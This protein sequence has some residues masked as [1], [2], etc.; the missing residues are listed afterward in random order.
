MVFNLDIFR[1][2][3]RAFIITDMQSRK[4][5]I[6]ASGATAV[7]VLLK[8]SED[9]LERTLYVG[10]VGDSRAILVTSK[11]PDNI[12]EQTASGYYGRRLTYDHRA[13][14]EGEQERI[15][16]AGGFVTRGRV[17]GIL[18][19]TR[20]F[21]DH[22]MKDFVSAS[23]YLTETRLNDC[24]ECPVLIL[25]CDGV[26]DVMTDQEAADMLIERFKA[27]GGPDED[28]AKFIVKTAIKRGSADNITAIVVYL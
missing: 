22:G 7:S 9:G 10:N 6:V 17:L 8:R 27:K 2:L 15:K 20:S 11:S 28:A 1:L 3:L 16:I 18:A 4:S 23:P 19:V 12:A 25:A 21:G 26:W 14:D 24:G 5:G 13:E